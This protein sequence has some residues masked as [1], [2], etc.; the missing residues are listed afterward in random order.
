MEEHLGSVADSGHRG[1]EEA[2]EWA[3][4]GR[5]TLHQAPRCWP[6]LKA[7]GSEAGVLGCWASEP[8]VNQDP[9]GRLLLLP[10]LLPSTPTPPP[11]PSPSSLRLPPSPL[12]RRAQ[13]DAQGGDYDPILQMGKVRPERAGTCS[14]IA[15]CHRHRLPQ[16]RSFS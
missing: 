10:A 2:G 3:G 6:W 14:G 9:A 11:E 8:G 12:D 15:L 16:R 7:Q 1:N 5:A 4:R 13:G